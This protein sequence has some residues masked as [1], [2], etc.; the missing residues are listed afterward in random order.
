MEWNKA[1]AIFADYSPFTV[2]I[3]NN[4][5]LISYQTMDSKTPTP[6]P[7]PPSFFTFAHAHIK[8]LQSAGHL[9]LAETRQSAINSF[10]RFLF[11][12]DMPLDSFSQ[13]KVEQYESWLKSQGLTRNTT[14]FYMRNLRAIYHAAME[15]GIVATDCHPFARVYT[16]VDKTAKRAI[17]LEDLNRIKMLELNRH[18]ALSLARDILMFSFYARG[19]SFVDMAYLRK[20]DVIGDHLFYYRRKT[21]QM[22]VVELLPQ[23]LEIIA[24]LPALSSSPFLLPLIAHEGSTARAQ[25]RKALININRNLKKIG[26]MAQISLPLTTYVARH[27]WASIAQEMEIPVAI[28]SKGLGHDNV[29]TT[30]IYLDSLQTKRI[31]DA[32]RKIMQSL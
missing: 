4:S 9:R 29:K 10:K 31:D 16:G 17:G 24:R 14:S 12:V 20:K 32:N 27:S 7:G 28:I 26:Q 3:S 19:M 25:Y 13:E 1:N 30:Q 22:V 21:H 23:M 6:L 2:I 8:R 18:P 5:I 15:Q 11:G